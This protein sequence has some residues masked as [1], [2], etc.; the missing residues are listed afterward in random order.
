MVLIDLDEGLFHQ[1]GRSMALA[2][3]SD[4]RFY[5]RYWVGMY[6]P[7]GNRALITGMGAYKNNDAIDA[8]TTYQQDGIQTNVRTARRLYPDFNQVVGPIRHDIVEPLKRLR[9]V[10]EA[11]DE[12]PLSCDLMWIANTPP[13]E[14]KQHYITHNTRIVQ[15]YTRYDQAGWVEGTITYDGETIDCDG[16]VALRDHAWGTRPGVG[17]FEPDIGPLW[18]NGF[19]YQWMCWTTGEVSG[20]IQ[21]H[22]QGD[23][24]PIYMDGKIRYVGKDDDPPLHVVSGDIDVEFVAGTR[25]YERATAIVRCHDGSEWTV[26]ATPLVTAWHMHGTGYDRGYDDHRAHGWPRP[27]GTLEWDQY[28]IR[29]LKMAY[30]LPDRQEVHGWHREQPARVTCNGTAGTG[31]FTII[32]RAPLPRYGFLDDLGSEEITDVPADG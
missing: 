32:P 23:D 11:S 12:Y 21:I 20:Y 13:L 1:D 8:F 5:D 27:N 9:F 26:E 24:T 17:G 2:S 10:L 19:L 15:D 3:T 7:A 31:H 6:D 16:W 22:N 30:L 4:H 25:V 14:E 18:R 28:D 29:D